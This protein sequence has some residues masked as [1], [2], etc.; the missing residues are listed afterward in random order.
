MPRLAVYPFNPFI[1]WHPQWL[2]TNDTN[3]LQCF[4][5]VHLLVTSFHIPHPAFQ[6][7][8]KRSVRPH[9][10]LLWSLPFYVSLCTHC[11][12]APVQ[13]SEIVFLSMEMECVWRPRW[14][15]GISDVK[16]FLWEGGCA[17]PCM[18]VDFIHCWFCPYPGFAITFLKCPFRNVGRQAHSVWFLPCP[19]IQLVFYNY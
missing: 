6:G 2:W 9:W 5:L 14:R 4:Q 8:M 12:E 16:D 3:C 18:L 17:G 19:T 10:G 11:D 13:H 7:R 1:L 15:A